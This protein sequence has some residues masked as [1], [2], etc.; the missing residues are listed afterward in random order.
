MIARVLAV[1]LGG[2]GVDPVIIP[3]TVVVPPATV[4]SADLI[5][6]SIGE[7]INAVVKHELVGDVRAG[8]AW[9]IRVNIRDNPIASVLDGYVWA[10]V[11]EI[12]VWNSNHEAGIPA[13]GLGRVWVAEIIGAW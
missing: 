8:N 4:G 11:I 10:A 2:V 1:G 5:K 13:V 12:G 7:T 9:G 6:T 3:I